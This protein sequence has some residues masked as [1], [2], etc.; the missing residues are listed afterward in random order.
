MRW[1]I[2]ITTVRSSRKIRTMPGQVQLTIG[3]R[4]TKFSG[5]RTKSD[6]TLGSDSGGGLCA[7][8]ILAATPW[9]TYCESDIDILFEPCIR[10]FAVCLYLALQRV[11]VACACNVCIVLWQVRVCPSSQARWR[12]YCP[13]SHFLPTRW[14]KLNILPM[15][16]RDGGLLTWGV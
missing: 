7:K 3:T 13:V 8:P 15:N 11:H 5:L 6:L 16:F 2:T 12:L 9:V 10:Y 4:C 14:M 1:S